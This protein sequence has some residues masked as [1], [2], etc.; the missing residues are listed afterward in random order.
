MLRAIGTGVL[1]PGQQ[2]PTMRQ[3]AV[4][5]KV[6]LNTIRHAYEELERLGAISLMRGRGIV[7][8]RAVPPQVA[9]RERARGLDDFARQTI[10]AARRRWPGQRRRLRPY[11]DASASG[12]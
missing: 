10:V 4:A 1:K 3:V 12:K 9:P 7:R 2:M 8:G 6:D 5:L 11:R